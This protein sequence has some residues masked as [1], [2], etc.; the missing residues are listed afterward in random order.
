MR[1]WNTRFLIFFM[2][3]AIAITLY[4]LFV[5]KEM[6]NEVFAARVFFTSCITTLIYF[7][8]LRRNEKKSL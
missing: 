2:A 7:I 5:K 8:V 3:I 1:I 6:L 4:G